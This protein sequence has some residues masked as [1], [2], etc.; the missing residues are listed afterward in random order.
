MITKPLIIL[1][2]LY[3]LVFFNYSANK[4][5]QKIAENYSK[6]SYVSA[7]ADIG[8]VVIPR[9]LN[10]PYAK[11]NSPKA[12]INSRYYM[13]VDGDSG[14]LLA[15]KSE[16]EKTPIASTTKIMTAVIAL[17]NYDL[18]EVVT[19]PP[20]ATSQ[21]PTLVN[22]RSGEEI[23]VFEL[24]N[25]LL[26]KSGND[27]AFAIATHMDQPANS[28]IRPFVDKMN[29]KA[30]E[31]GM[32]S[33]HYEDPA[34]LNDSGYSTASD[35][36]IVTRYALQNSTFRQVVKTP[37]YT[38]KNTT[39]TFF[40]K[41]ENSNRLITTYQYPGAIG[42]KTGF[43]YAASHSLVAA[44]KR[45]NHTL[46]AVILSTYVDSASASADEARK[47]LDWGFANVIWP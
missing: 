5:D 15:S 33:T 12:Y 14:S 7:S 26:I 20:A 19:T 3:S 39:E 16:D 9:L 46:I 43:T 42:V 21:T 11:T 2:T 23:S 31:L 17:E 1:S 10:F 40:H 32:K 44:A 34:G 38:A 41:L 36:A 24:L 25:C 30:K 4:A 13:L 6:E 47:L 35:L 22:L 29:N 8:D 18:N 37:E 28:D 27:A 45:E